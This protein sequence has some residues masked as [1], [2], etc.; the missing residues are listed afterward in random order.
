MVFADIFRGKFCPISTRQAHDTAGE[1]FLD[2]PCDCDTPDF[3][4]IDS[5]AGRKP[6]KASSKTKGKGCIRR[7]AVML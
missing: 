1:E 2:I 5:M 7:V 3:V 6:E 4:D